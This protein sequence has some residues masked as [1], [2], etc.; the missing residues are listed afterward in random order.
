[1]TALF[2]QPRANGS[3]DGVIMGFLD[4]AGVQP[5]TF[6]LTF[7]SFPI[8]AFIVIVVVVV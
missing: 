3:F 7:S 4:I 1:M 8:W 6:C 2:S 5:D